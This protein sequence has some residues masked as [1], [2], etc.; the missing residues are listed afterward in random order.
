MHAVA[1]VEADEVSMAVQTEHISAV[2]KTTDKLISTESKQLLLAEGR[3][4]RL[5][6]ETPAATDRRTSVDAEEE[7][8]NSPM[9]KSSAARSAKNHSLSSA[10]TTQRFVVK[11][12]T[13]RHSQDFR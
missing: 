8:V 1:V 3:D 13:H 12:C 10:N 11:V 6:T 7:T 2:S 5:S 4:T 9:S